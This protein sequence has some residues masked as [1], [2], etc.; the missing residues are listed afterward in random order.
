[1]GVAK[2]DEDLLQADTVRPAGPDQDAYAAQTVVGE[3]SPQLLEA[4]RKSRG[5]TLDG[6]DLPRL[7]QEEDEEEEDSFGSAPRP[8]A[9]SHPALVPPPLAQEAVSGAV[10]IGTRGPD[11]ADPAE[12]LDCDLPGPAASAS[13]DPVLEY[14]LESLPPSEVEQPSAAAQTAE[15]PR[16]NQ[17]IG[18]ALLI[19][20]LVAMAVGAAVLALR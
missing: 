12:E 6:L 18:V 15:P 17:W 20:Y 9:E 2:R 14:R 11:L 8:I 3:A 16:S 19:A 4:I 5:E 1:M 10:V 7:S 13:D